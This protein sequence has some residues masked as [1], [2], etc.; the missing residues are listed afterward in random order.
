MRTNAKLKKI[1]SEKQQLNLLLCKG[2]F[3]A[4]IIYIRKRY[5]IP[6]NGFS[7][8]EEVNKWYDILKAN[9]ENFLK[10][11]WYDKLEEIE[12]VGSSAQ[13]SDYLN[14]L[15]ESKKAIFDSSPYR[16]YKNEIFKLAK[17]HKLSPEWEKYLENYIIFNDLE[18][19]E[20]NAE[21]NF[22]IQTDKFNDKRK[23][24]INIYEDTTIDDIKAIWPRITKVQESLLSHKK[25]KRQPMQQFERD[26]LAYEM[27]HNGYSL[28]SIAKELN[29]K[30]N[31]NYL[32][33]E[34][35]KFVKRHKKKV[36]Q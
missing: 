12:F 7:N 2:Q 16:L 35:P 9:T 32:D 26:K 18:M 31:A 21:I 20:W 27:K 17:K 28:K 8:K 22:D 29:E 19:I 36:W 13:K 3:N 34:I 10:E 5:K 24:V 23:I 4:D 33:F 15:I 11:V 6:N 30:Y 14:K 1:E 25:T